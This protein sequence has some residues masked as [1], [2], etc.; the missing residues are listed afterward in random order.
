MK[1]L[2]QIIKDFREDA[3]LDQTTVAKHLGISQQTYS[4]YERGVSDIP[5]SCLSSLSKLYNVNVEYLLGLTEYREKLTYLNQ[6][7]VDHVSVGSTLSDLIFLNSKNRSAVLT[8]IQ[9]LKDRQKNEQKER[10]S[11]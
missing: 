4:R 3:D 2:H 7:F 11:M 5:A 8:Y 1:E 10:T 9:Y 6:P